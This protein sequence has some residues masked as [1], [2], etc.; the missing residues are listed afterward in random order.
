MDQHDYHD[1]VFK[2]R[3]DHENE[4]V[5][6]ADGLCIEDAAEEHVRAA[7]WRL[8]GEISAQQ[9]CVVEDPEGGLWTVGI[10][11]YYEPKLYTQDPV[12]V[13]SS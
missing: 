10:R 2:V 1:G 8:N 5:E 4:F 12:K 6:Y 13:S 3:F 7:L 11:I 9:T